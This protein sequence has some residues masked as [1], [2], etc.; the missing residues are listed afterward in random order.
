MQLIPVHSL[1]LHSHLEQTPSIKLGVAFSTAR[2]SSYPHPP[3]NCIEIKNLK[4]DILKSLIE[5]RKSLP[6]PSSWSATSPAKTKPYIYCYGRRS[7][8]Y[9]TRLPFA[10]GAY[11]NHVWRAYLPIRV[12]QT[13][14]SSLILVAWGTCH[15]TFDS[16]HGRQGQQAEMGA[17]SKGR[18]GL[19]GEG[20]S[21]QHDFLTFW[22]TCSVAG[23]MTLPGPA[24]SPFI[25]LENCS[26]WGS[27][28]LVC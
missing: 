25:N 22:N 26:A 8:K 28:S 20:C 15:F 9:V 24:L 16:R 12:P 23:M 27:A 13:R 18:E 21:S 2:C 4:M 3:K 7:I 19:V 6:R 5:V 17:H 14:H 10:L 1:G 11:D